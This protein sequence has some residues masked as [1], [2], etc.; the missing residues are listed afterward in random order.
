MPLVYVNGAMVAEDDARVSVFDA[1]FQHGVGLFETLRTYGGKFFRLRRHVE[2]LLGSAA[3]LGLPPIGSAEE[4]E[5]AVRRTVAENGL[6]D[7]RVRLCATRGRLGNADSP[8]PTVVV[9]AAALTPY[10]AELYENG[11]AVAVA[12]IRQNETDPTSRHKTLLYFPRLLALEIARKKGC[13][14][15]LFFNSAK[16]L[17]EGAISN[18]FLVEDG[19]LFT[20]SLETGILAGVTRAA[21]IELASAEGIKT[22]EK[23]LTIHDLL[24]ASEVFLTNSIMEVMPVVRVE[25]HQVG[26]GRPGIRT[27]LLREKYA[28]AALQ[29]A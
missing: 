4:L 13:G 22:V 26:D 14:E 21:V 12:D 28:A 6:A 17:A 27:R 23:T 7:A 15:A 25:R 2:R 19:A 16:H 10:P 1:G 24:T 20:P 3:A 5:A 11:M 18:I 8:T 9:T 29:E